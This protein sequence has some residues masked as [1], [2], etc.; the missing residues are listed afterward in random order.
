MPR[1]HLIPNVSYDHVFDVLFRVFPLLT[2]FRFVFAE[3]EREI[4]TQRNEIP[5][6]KVGLYT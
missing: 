6:A 1:F 3:N 5:E 2:L 4:Q